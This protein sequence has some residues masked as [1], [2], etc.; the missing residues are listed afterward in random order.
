MWGLSRRRRY[1]H[2]ESIEDDYLDALARW[3]IRTGRDRHDMTPEQ[4]RRM[5]EHHLSLNAGIDM[6]RVAFVR[7]LVA[8]GRIGEHAPLDE[9]RARCWGDEG[10]GY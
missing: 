4:A 6:V 9:A 7:S 8:T 3:Q 2:A 10:T 5:R 1:H